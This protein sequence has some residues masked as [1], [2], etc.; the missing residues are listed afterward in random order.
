MAQSHAPGSQPGGQRR[1]PRAGRQTSGEGSGEGAERAG[2]TSA[3]S[4]SAGLQEFFDEF[5]RALTAGEAH[6]LAGLW[7]VPALLLGDASVQG[8]DSIAEVQ[9][10]FR[11]ARD[12]Y[13][14]RGISQARAEIVRASWPTDRIAV[15]EVRWPYVDQQ[16]QAV[17]EETSTYTLRCNDDGDLRLRVAVMHGAR[18]LH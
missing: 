18:N 4:R 2:L 10:L 17:G 9:S 16:G 12:R 8:L 14:A 1:P 15:V 11:G 7:E 3:E 5:A 6:T 13:N